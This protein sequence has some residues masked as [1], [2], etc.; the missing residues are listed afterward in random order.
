VR[1]GAGGEAILPPDSV[2]VVVVGAA[3]GPEHGRG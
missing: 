2:A 3:P 1:L